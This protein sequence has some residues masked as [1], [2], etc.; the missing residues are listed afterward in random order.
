MLRNFAAS[1]G[2]GRYRV[3]VQA[4]LTADG[5]IVQV[6]GGEK[7][8]VGAVVFSL[9]RPSQSEPGTLRATSTVVPRYGHRDDELARPVAER[10]VTALGHPVVVVAGVHIA[11]A[12]PEE[13]KLLVANAH[14]AVEKL[15]AVINAASG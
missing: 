5:L 11:A 9:P 15:I 12:T 2:Q 13:I 14:Q 4:T 10:L 1:A 6:L 3:E 7:P 8:H